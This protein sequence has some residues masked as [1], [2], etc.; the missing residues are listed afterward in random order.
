MLG[1][2]FDRAF[3]LASDL[4]RTQVRKATTI[5]YLSHLMAVTALV[6]EFGGDEDQAIAALLHDSA[7]DQGGQAVLDQI[8]TEFGADVAQ[9]VAELS[10]SL[11][12]TGSRDKAPWRER[13]EAYLA[14]LPHHSLR[15]LLISACDKLHNSGTILRALQTGQADL[16]N[17]F[18]GGRDG[19]LWYYNQLLAVFQTT[20]LPRELLLEYER[21]IRQMNELARA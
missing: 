6:L 4:H 11:E 17:R 10:D 1:P 2:R 5:P 16:W 13:K 9:M 21:V 20:G 12:D 18:K 7:E 15:V 14:Q 3:Q 19:S 8:K